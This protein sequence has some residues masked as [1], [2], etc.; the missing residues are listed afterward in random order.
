MCEI[1]L[2]RGQLFVTT[3]SLICLIKPFTTITLFICVYFLKENYDTKERHIPNSSIVDKFL[4]KMSSSNCNIWSLWNWY[5]RKQQNIRYLSPKKKTS[6]P[7]LKIKHF[8]YGRQMLKTSRSKK[9]SEKVLLSRQWHS[10][11]NVILNWLRHLNRHLN[12]RFIK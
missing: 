5:S 4:E 10:Q 8:T 6:L 7:L 3:K 2:T 11:E 9:L 1:P 12:K